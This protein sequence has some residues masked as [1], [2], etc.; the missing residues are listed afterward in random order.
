VALVMV[1]ME[2][3][4]VSSED[5]GFPF[6]SSHLL[7]HTHRHPSSGV[8]TIGHRYEVKMDR[9]SVHI[10]TKTKCGFQ[11]SLGHKIREDKVSELKFK[12]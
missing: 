11:Y 5:F 1:Q 2:L 12:N 4:Q 9:L 6:Q 7:L 3:E 10:Y 8:G